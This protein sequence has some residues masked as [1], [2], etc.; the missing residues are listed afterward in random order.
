[1]FRGTGNDDR[2]FPVIIELTELLCVS[3]ISDKW[4]FGYVL[5]FS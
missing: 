3:D 4:G 1:V 5:S 2:L